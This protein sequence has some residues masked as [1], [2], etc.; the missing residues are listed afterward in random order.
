ME[1]LQEALANEEF[2]EKVM[3]AISFSILSRAQQRA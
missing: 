3:V 2:S 1:N